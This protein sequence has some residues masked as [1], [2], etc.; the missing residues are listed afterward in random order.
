MLPFWMRL[1]VAKPGER[2]ITL[3]FPVIIVWVFV[4]ALMLLLLPFVLLA[5]LVTRGRGTG[6]VL[7]LAYPMLW[8]VLGNLSGLHIE[9]NAVGESVLVDFR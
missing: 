3:G 4:A 8:S 5:A 2:R 6:R 9:V 1:R 7:L